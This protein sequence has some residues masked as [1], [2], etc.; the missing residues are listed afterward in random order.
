MVAYNDEITLR[1]KLGDYSDEV[2]ALTSV[3]GSSEVFITR[4][5]VIMYMLRTCTYMKQVQCIWAHMQNY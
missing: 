4:L 2:S 3:V 5:V 1:W